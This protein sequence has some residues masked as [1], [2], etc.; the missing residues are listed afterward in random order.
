MDD[1]ALKIYDYDDG[2]GVVVQFIRLSEL[3]SHVREMFLGWNQNQT[4]P[5]VNLEGTEYGDAVSYEDF[6]R[7]IHEMIPG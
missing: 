2:S 7:F 6:R 4:A 5:I 3:A 1:F